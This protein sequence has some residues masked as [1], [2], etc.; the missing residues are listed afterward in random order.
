MRKE[1]THRR[2]PALLLALSMLLNCAPAALAAETAAW[3]RLGYKKVLGG[4]PFQCL[5]GHIYGRGRYAALQRQLPGSLIV[6]LDYDAGLRD[7][8]V[9]SRVRMLLDTEL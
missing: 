5:P 9:E 4:L 3:V 6:G 2:L 8:T 7:V 1:G